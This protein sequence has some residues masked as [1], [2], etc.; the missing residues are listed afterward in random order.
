MTF[1]GSRST[2][3]G[4]M[5]DALLDLSSSVNTNESEPLVPPPKKERL[6]SLDAFRGLV[7]ASAY[8]RS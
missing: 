5:R 1:Y 7:I 2:V 8:Q 3:G 4:E 6:K